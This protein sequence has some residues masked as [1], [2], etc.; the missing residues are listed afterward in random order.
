MKKSTRKSNKNLGIP[1]NI[2]KTSIHLSNNIIVHTKKKSI[3]E[4]WLQKNQ[5]NNQ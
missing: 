4:T 2:Y 5:F 3:G 1:A